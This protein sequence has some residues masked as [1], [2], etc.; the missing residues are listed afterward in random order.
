MLPCRSLN[1]T[2]V[3][4][5][6][7]NFFRDAVEDSGAGRVD[8]VEGRRKRLGHR[9]A[10]P[11]FC[12]M[13]EAQRMEYE[14]AQHADLGCWLLRMC[15]GSSDEVDQAFAV[16]HRDFGGRALAFARHLGLDEEQAKDV[17][18]NV[19]L[20]VWRALKTDTYDCNRGSFEGWLFTCIRNASNDEHRKRRP[21]DPCSTHWD[22]SEPPAL[23]RDQGPAAAVIEEEEME[24]LDQALK[25]GLTE[26]QYTVVQLTLG[27]MTEKQIDEY[28]GTN[29]ARTHLYRARQRIPGILEQLNLNESQKVKKR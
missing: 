13:S 5:R 24:R 11:L 10:G 7:T 26:M 4:S 12:T 2:E 6:R 20:K 23:L 8:V 22:T 29:S 19:L 17:W 27:G 9:S 16:L 28:L 1:Q 15:R 25:E 18:Q 21:D 3:D 14:N